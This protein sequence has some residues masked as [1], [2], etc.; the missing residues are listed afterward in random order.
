MLHHGYGKTY[1]RCLAPLLGESS[2]TVAE[3]GILTGTG[4][5]IWCDLFPGARVIGFDIDLS[6]FE[7]NRATLLRRGAFRKNQPELHEYDQLIDNRERLGE[8]LGGQTLDVVI[9]DGLHSAESIVTTWRSV[10]PHLSRR[11]VYFIEDYDGLLDQCSG[12]FSQFDCRA[13]GMLT[14]VSS[15][16][17]L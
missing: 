15:G 13:F 3:F 9:D 7:E 12:E 5:A 11:F 2:L 6:H 1:A 4:L 16:V 8:V 17:H 10:A 14:V